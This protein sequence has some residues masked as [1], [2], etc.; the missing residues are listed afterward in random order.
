MSGYDSKL[1]RLNVRLLTHGWVKMG[2]A[3]ARTTCVKG[4]CHGRKTLPTHASP[5][6]FHEPLLD[7]SPYCKTLLPRK[8]EQPRSAPANASYSPS[9]KVRRTRIASGGHLQTPASSAYSGQATGC[10]SGLPVLQHYQG[11]LVALRIDHLPGLLY[12]GCWAI[13]AEVSVSVEGSL[14]IRDPRFGQ[15]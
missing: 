1:P 6:G 7:F 15:E 4:F 13:P 10:P 9:W 11:G 3:T 12:V 5:S 8:Q 14:P 2:R